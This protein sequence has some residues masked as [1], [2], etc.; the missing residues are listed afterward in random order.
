MDAKERR[1]RAISRQLR[2]ARALEPER[3]KLVLEL[4]SE[5]GR[6]RLVDLAEMTGLT[7]ARI[8][9]IIGK[10]GKLSEDTRDAP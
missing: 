3:D 4:A 10:A 2:A 6:G 5:R 1:L 9:Q 7:K 8:H